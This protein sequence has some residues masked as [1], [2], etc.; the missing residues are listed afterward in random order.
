MLQFA[1]EHTYAPRAPG[2]PGRWLLRGTIAPWRPDEPRTY[3]A[4]RLLVPERP[5]TAHT[6]HA[7]A[8]GRTAGLRPLTVGLTDDHVT[9]NMITAVP[10]TV[11]AADGTTAEAALPGPA[12]EAALPVPVDL[13]DLELRTAD[14]GRLVARVPRQ[15]YTGAAY[16]LA[17]GVVTV[18]AELPASA[19]AEEALCLTGTGSG[20][21]APGT[22]LREKEI[23]VQVDDASLIL[24]HPRGP[25]DA[26]HDVEVLVRSFVRGRPAAVGGIGVRQFFNPQG[27]C[28]AIRAARNPKGAVARN[29]DIVPAAR[30]TAG[31]APGTGSGDGSGN[32]DGAWSSALCP[33]HGPHRP[34]LVHPAGRG[35]RYRPR[36]ALRRRR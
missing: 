18:P 16:A 27:P 24:E 1:L 13:G 26:D 6:A 14:S 11:R 9:L 31:R 4:G 10:A 25:D 12:A 32:G 28:R 15:A 7:T 36:P 17:S 21:Y 20:P 30:G 3:P 33:G 29:L 22:L 34:G 35:G 8:A 2:R 5:H 23:N 19:V